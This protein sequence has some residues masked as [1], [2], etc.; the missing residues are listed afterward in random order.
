MEFSVCEGMGRL[1]SINKRYQK[2]M[3]GRK[4]MGRSWVWSIQMNGLFTLMTNI[5]WNLW[6]GRNRIIKLNPN[7][8]TYINEGYL[9]F[10]LLSAWT[11]LRE[12]FLLILI[13]TLMMEALRSSETSVLTS[14]TSQ[15]TAFSN[16]VVFTNKFHIILSR[17]IG[18]HDT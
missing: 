7:C 9:K 14:P 1:I 12:Y 18:Q 3:E 4:D 6:S 13:V 16:R 2:E 8:T 5:K 17:I 11:Q 15:K 10:L